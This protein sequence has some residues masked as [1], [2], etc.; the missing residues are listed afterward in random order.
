M[1]V[2]L[3]MNV[4][5]VVVSVLPPRDAVAGA[6]DEPGACLRRR[7]GRRVDDRDPAVALRIDAVGAA[8][9]VGRDARRYDRAVVED[10]AVDARTH[11]IGLGCLDQPRGEIANDVAARRDRIEVDGLRAA[12]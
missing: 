10:G 8:R 6:F 9:G 4:P 1:F 11:R 5:S 3:I 12:L 2:M 7:A